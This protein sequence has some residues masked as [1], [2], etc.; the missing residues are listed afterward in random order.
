MK[1]ALKAV[2]GAAAAAG[3]AVLVQGVGALTLGPLADATDGNVTATTAV[4]VRTSPTTQSQSLAVIYKGHTLP[5]HGSKNGWTTVTYNGKTAYVASAYL[6]G[7]SAEVKSSS[8][9]STGTV[10][11]TANL[12]MRTGPSTSHR[13]AFVAQRGTAVVL[14]GEVSG[15][16]AQVKVN[17]GT[18]WASTRYLS[19][20][21]AAAYHELPT[22]VGK[23]RGTTALMIR[24]TSTSSFVNLGD[25]PRGT[26][27]N[28]TGKLENGMSQV[29]WQGRLRWVNAKYLVAVDATASA[30]A[31][32]P[33]TA[34]PSTTVRYATTLLNNWAASTGTRYSGEFPR[35]SELNVTGKVENGRAQIVHNGAIRWVTAKYVSATKPTDSTASSGSSTTLNR[36]Y[37]SG[38]DLTNA[39]VQAIV[40]DVW[41]RY[42][43]ITTMY[44]WRR[45]VTPDHPA[46]R[47]VDVMIPSYSSNQALGWEIANYYRANASKY[48]INYII[49]A[50]KI[51]SVQRNSE[52]WRWMS[53]RG[54]DNAN[55]YNH[56]HINTY[57]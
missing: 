6:A 8:G 1:K 48:N 16:F 30:P 17:G 43:A 7:S 49:F 28:V 21:A 39:N 31:P 12:N 45:D 29:I 14:T 24:T 51:W 23:M 36:G 33:T 38:L 46:G 20:T 2:R 25:A 3:I 41:D 22:P 11:T 13:S 40:R 15:E 4:H 56:V 18:Y 35:G 47:A 27:F 44:G 37:S 54:S 57:G 42:P 34:L 32:A 53:D 19:T 26:I 9:G 10:Y 55:H 52:G 50:Q 5:A